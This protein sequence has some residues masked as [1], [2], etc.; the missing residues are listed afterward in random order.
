MNPRPFVLG[1][2][3]RAPVIRRVDIQG[4][5]RVHLQ[6]L[7]HL[8]VAGRILAL[9]AV[10]H[11]MWGQGKPP[12]ASSWCLVGLGPHWGAGGPGVFPQV[13]GEEQVGPEFGGPVKVLGLLARET[14][15]PRLGH[16]GNG[17][18]RPARGTRVREHLRLLPC[19]R[20]SRRRRSRR[21]W[22]GHA[23][24]E[25]RAALLREGPAPLFVALTALAPP[26][27]ASQAIVPRDTADFRYHETLLHDPTYRARGL[28]VASGQVESV[29]T[30]V[31]KQRL[32]LAGIRWRAAALR[33]G[34][35]RLPESL[36]QQ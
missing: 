12:P 30:V 21:L 22:G 6:D 29:E 15:D 14:D 10:L 13:E 18:G 5:L 27:D 36:S 2:A 35:F 34:C 1:P 20:S 23:R 24:N 7:A 3:H 19:R 4:Y 11:P 32:A 25:Q 9:E 28:P 16:R 17:A 31:L 8:V 26:S 33:A